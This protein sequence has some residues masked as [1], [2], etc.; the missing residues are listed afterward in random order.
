MTRITG[1]FR[2]LVPAIP[3]WSE[4]IGYPPDLSVLVQQNA[5]TPDEKTIV[6]FPSCISRIMGSYAGREKNIM[7]TFMRVCSKSGIG[8]IIPE[9]IKGSCC[10]QVFSSKGCKDAC[11]FTA[12]D[13]VARL[14]Q[15]TR[16]VCCRW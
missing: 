11:Q 12:N 7:E 9:N 3:L 6:Y 14:W 15:A 13:I 2:K 1:V 8:V 4:Q 5:G 10:S 16:K